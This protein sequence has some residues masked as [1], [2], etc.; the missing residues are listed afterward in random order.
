VKWLGVD[1]ALGNAGW[2]LLEDEVAL[3]SGVIQTEPSNYKGVLDSLYRAQEMAVWF[4]GL[5]EETTPDAVACEYPAVRGHRTESSLLAA[6]ALF[7]SVRVMGPGSVTVVNAQQ[8]RK[9]FA[10]VDK[11]GLKEVLSARIDHS[12]CNQ[13]NQHITDALGVAIAARDGKGTGVVLP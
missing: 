5:L 7:Q 6:S 4:L 13:W 11:A 8:V 2:V 3:A 1:Q 9:H 12:S 10:V